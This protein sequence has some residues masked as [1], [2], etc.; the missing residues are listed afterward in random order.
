MHATVSGGAIPIAADP[1]PSSDA[2]VPRTHRVIAVVGLLM[3]VAASCGLVT[4]RPRAAGSHQRDGSGWLLPRVR[5]DCRGGSSATG[6]AYLL[7]FCAACHAYGT[8]EIGRTVDGGATWQ[9]F[10]FL[11]HPI[12]A[13]GGT[14]SFPTPR[15]G[16]AVVEWD[17]AP[18]QRRSALLS[19]VDGG[20]TWAPRQLRLSTTAQALP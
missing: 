18:L 10:A 12:S 14:V 6:D 15:P 16:W 2:T 1:S 7:G 9:N 19:T 11:D 20:R 17:R 4:N 8:T 3:L 5:H 13:G